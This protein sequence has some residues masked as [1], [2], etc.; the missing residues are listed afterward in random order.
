M[1][2]PDARISQLSRERA[3]RREAFER[4]RARLAGAVREQMRP[5]RL[6]RNHPQLLVGPAMWLVSVLGLRK[7]AAFNGNGRSR[8]GHGAPTG[9]LGWIA[10]IAGFGGGMAVKTVRP[11]AA[12]ALR[13]AVKSLVRK[14]RGRR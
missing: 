14:L 6:V 13:F 11:F 2:F 12:T 7:I 5:F 1:M 3:V 10:R 9:A 4:S 8:N